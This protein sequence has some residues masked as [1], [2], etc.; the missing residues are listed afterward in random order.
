MIFEALDFI[1]RLAART[2][3]VP[4]RDSLHRTQTAPSLSPARA[5]ASLRGFLPPA[6]RPIALACAED[7]PVIERILNHLA[8][9]DL[10]G[11]WP[12]SRA[13]P[14]QPVGLLH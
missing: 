10:P 12:E 4:A 8:S 2:G 3:A 14:A 1:A 5:T 9:K 11:L 13:P 7:P 6:N